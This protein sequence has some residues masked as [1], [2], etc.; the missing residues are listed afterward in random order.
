MYLNMFEYDISVYANAT[1]NDA[2]FFRCWGGVGCAITFFIDVFI[3]L[4]TKF[5]LRYKIFSC[6]CTE[7]VME[8][9]KAIVWPAAQTAEK[10]EVS[11]HDH[12]V[13]E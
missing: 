5:T 12:D 11:C 3:D 6:T 10:K 1:H 2:R 4:H 9:L 7:Q 8:H 13:H